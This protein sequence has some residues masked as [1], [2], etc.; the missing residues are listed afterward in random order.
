[1]LASTLIVKKRN[2]DELEGNEIDFLIRGFCRGEVADYQMSAFAMAVCLNGMTPRETTRLT[3]AML[4]SGEVLPRS[5]FD[6]PPRVD[7][8]STGGLGDKVSLILAPLLACCDV[9]VPMVSGRGLGLSGGTLD[10]L[11]SIEG[12]RVEYS[13]EEATKLLDQTGAFIISAN[14]TLA[15]ADRRLYALRDV[16]GT[17][18]SIPLITASILSKKLAASLDALVMDVKVGSGAFMKT[19][20]QASSLANSLSKVGHQAG[21]PT[22]ALITDMDQP[23]GETLGNAIEVNEAVEVLQGK[24]GVVRDLTIELCAVLLKQAQVDSS[25][26]AAKKRLEETLDSGQAMQRFEQMVQAQSGTWSGP[27]PVAQPHVITAEKS[28][29]IAALDCQRL[30]Q[31]IVALQGGR[32]QKGDRI[33]HRIGIRVH[34]RI[35]DFVERD[36]PLLTLYCDKSD[37]SEYVTTIR[38]A[39]LLSEQRVSPRDL[40]LHRQS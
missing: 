9:L 37:I 13:S 27:L 17:V 21:L 19:I 6:G 38:D 7:K 20:D 34:H 2:G 11:E 10:K 1:M 16:T 35:G 26:P 39:V 18:E 25:L 12:F 24:P 15:P 3:H 30:G 23:L 22:T 8:H 28:G 4:H 40:I 5:A 31:T 14:E 33:N 32:R 36:A 29:S